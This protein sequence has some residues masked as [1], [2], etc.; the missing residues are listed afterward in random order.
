MKIYDI[1]N[2]KGWN[3]K[4]LADVMMMKLSE[5]GE[6]MKA[7]LNDL[8]LN[9]WNKIKPKVKWGY[10]RLNIKETMDLLRNGGTNETKKSDSERVENT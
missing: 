7:V 5:Y 2:D 9:D 4:S 6:V 3:Y 10:P 1:I 8:L